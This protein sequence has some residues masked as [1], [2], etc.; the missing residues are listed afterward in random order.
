MTSTPSPSGMPAT[1]AFPFSAIVGH[2]ELKRALLLNAVDARI[3]GVLI[4]GDR[5]TAK[6]TAVRALRWVLPPVATREGCPVVCDP[7][8]ACAF[9]GVAGAVVERPA[10]IV[11]LPLGA[12][13]DRVAGSLDLERALAGGE[14]RF[15][16][17]LVA[18]AHRGVLYI[19]EVNLLPD[20]LVD[21]LLD[22]AASGVNVVE[23]DGASAAHAARFILV[24]TMNPEEGDLR[25]QLLDRF[26]LAVDIATPTDA[27]VRA[28]VVRRRIAFD[29]DPG[30]FV[31]RFAAEDAAL[32]AR[33]AAARARLDRV[34]VPPDVLAL[35]VQLCVE[36]G[37]DGLRA[38]ITL[39]R[40]AAALAALDARDHA[41]RQDVL[42]AAPLVLAHR[43]RPPSPGAPPP[44]PLSDLLDRH[45][46]P[47]T[48]EPATDESAA[49]GAPGD[50]VP[51][52]AASGE[53][54]PGAGGDAGAPARD[55]ASDTSGASMRA[56]APAD[57]RVVIALPE[58]RRGRRGR[59]ARGVS[60][61][62][63]GSA[64]GTHAWDGASR[65]IALFASRIAAAR[66]GR[67]AV[68]A[69][70]LRMHARRARTARLVVL[71][72]DGSGS[73]G[74]RER[75]ARTKAAL[76]GILDRVYQ[77]R[78]RVAV[79]V[80]RAGGSELLVAPGRSIAAARG[81]LDALPTGGGTPLDAALRSVTA[82]LLREARI[83]PDGDRLLI[84][85]TDGRARGDVEAA[86]RAA[87]RAATTTLVV[88]TEDG[89]VR[90]GR[91]R[92]LAAWLEGAYEAT[93]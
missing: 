46:E 30:A 86:A 72:V 18:A 66:A 60:P 29:A 23:R 53:G 27:E 73:M 77:R 54:T 69:G 57:E 34:E 3:G 92:A 84:V 26:G 68:Q 61:A 44:P 15:A 20:H 4:R 82:L 17:G 28:E 2:E 80:F 47:P 49:D 7:A 16:P 45:R 67:A 24:G 11:E 33:V 50:G 13:E 83:H 85:V 74:A 39:Y 32:C 14:R 70:D 90:L 59:A 42:A 38:D 5:G 9:C 65:D 21:L 19:D 78:D 22:V 64:A 89:P 88:D 75:M 58:A 55:R 37:A 41:T 1:P 6:S 81:A 25:P 52:D 35:I 87:A 43:Q 93:G 36:A 48:D 12:T 40:A 79:Q 63:R 31:A 91:A 76:R 51:G 62:P 71:L 8:S 56:T 10:A